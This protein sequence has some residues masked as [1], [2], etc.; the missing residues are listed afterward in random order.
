LKNTLGKKGTVMK[1][2]NR[3]QNAIV[4]PEDRRDY[5]TKGRIVNLEKEWTPEIAIAEPYD[6]AYLEASS[7]DYSVMVKKDEE[8]YFKRIDRL[9]KALI[10]NRIKF[11]WEGEEFV[12][13]AQEPDKEYPQVRYLYVDGQYYTFAT[14]EKEVYWTTSIGEFIEYVSEW[15][16]NTINE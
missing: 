9:Y 3:F 8:V 2:N 10:K 16:N 14:E 13:E 7:V 5:D 4:L 6:P 11:T 15:I 1:T 12:I